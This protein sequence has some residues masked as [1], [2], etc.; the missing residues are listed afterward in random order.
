MLPP[1]LLLIDTLLWIVL[2]AAVGVL[3]TGSVGAA[4]KRRGSSPLLVRGIRILLTVAWV[5]IVIAGLSVLFGPFSFVSTLTVSA[6]SGIAVTLALQ[7]T[8]QNIL[9]GFILAR[10]RFL[11]LGDQVQFSGLKGT[12]VSIG[13][14]A[15][16]IRME[17][18]SLATVSHS[19]LLSGP[20]V[21]FTATTRLAGE[22]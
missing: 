15:V 10:Y 13:L 9:S 14:V 4:L 2:P 19:N 21:N 17:G 1:D 16:V 8:L 5:S 7:T 3:L 20:F 11:R 12:I 18:G 22:Y 6:V